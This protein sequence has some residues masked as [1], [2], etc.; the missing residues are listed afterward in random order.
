MQGVFDF[1]DEELVSI[2]SLSCKA[3]SMFDVDTCIALNDNFVQL[4]TW[5]D[6]ERGHSNRLVNLAAYMKSIDG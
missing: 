6:T 3:W 4:V 5:C 1:T 2:D